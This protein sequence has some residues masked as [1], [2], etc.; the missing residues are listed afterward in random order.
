MAKFLFVQ[1]L[2]DFFE[3]SHDFE[4]EWD[5]GNYFKI[6]SKHGI[7][8]K[9]VE[10]AFDDSGIVPLGEQYEPIVF[11]TRLGVLGKTKEGKLL[12]ICFTFREEKVRPISAR[13][14]NLRERIIYEKAN[15]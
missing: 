15:S 2:V 1:W 3:F 12:F 5:E 13:N 7:L 11:E 9:E 6:V 4:F 14:A 8:P 10:A